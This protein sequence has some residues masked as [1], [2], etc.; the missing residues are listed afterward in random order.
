MGPTLPNLA[1]S[2]HKNGSYYSVTCHR[3]VL[4][5]LIFFSLIFENL[6]HVYNEIK[7]ILS[8]ITHFLTHPYLSQCTPPPNF[9]SLFKKML[10]LLYLFVI[11]YIYLPV[12]LC[13]CVHISV[14]RFV[15]MCA[16]SCKDQKHQIPLDL[17]SKE[18][19]SYSCGC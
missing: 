14:C 3:V 4:I 11:M 17:E 10:F 12:D 1:G 5:R 2:T 9:I 16:G 19:M 18:V 15:Y 6:I 8:L 7:I 13:T